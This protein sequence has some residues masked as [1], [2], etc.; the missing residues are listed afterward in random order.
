MVVSTYPKCPI[1]TIQLFGVEKRKPK[2]VG[3][4]KRRPQFLVKTRTTN[5]NESFDFQIFSRLLN[6]GNPLGQH[7]VIKYT[8]YTRIVYIKY[9]LSTLYLLSALRESRAF[10]QTKRQSST[11]EFS[12]ELFRDE[13]DSSVKLSPRCSIVAIQLFGVEKRKP[14][15]VVT[16]KRRPQFLIKTCT[17]NNNESCAF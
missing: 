14:K 16:L 3:P 12:H 9:T 2:E 8:K 1:V 4:L 11:I 10:F 15:E 17:T 7:H 6:C 5:S 13:N